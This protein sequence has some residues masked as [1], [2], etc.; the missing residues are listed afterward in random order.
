MRTP[1]ATVTARTDQVETVGPYAGISGV[2]S[3]RPITATAPADPA[4]RRESF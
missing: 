3:H 1:R 2:R 4:E